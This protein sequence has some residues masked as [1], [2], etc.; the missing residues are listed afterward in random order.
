MW[1]QAATDRHRHVG[2]YCQ[3]ARLVVTARPPACPPVTTKI[4]CS[5]CKRCTSRHT[6]MY[7]YSMPTT[8]MQHQQQHNVT[9]IDRSRSDDACTRKS[10]KHQIFWYYNVTIT[11]NHI[12]L[13]IYALARWLR[14]QVKASNE[15]RLLWRRVIHLSSSFRD[16]KI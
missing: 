1:P 9:M 12:T 13:Q 11:R 15:A 8:T 2:H 16:R 4:Q 14:P 3:L 6:T 10:S 5:K 7:L